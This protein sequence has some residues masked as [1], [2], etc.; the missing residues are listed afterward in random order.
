MGRGS[1][2]R[3]K[4]AVDEA[5]QDIHKLIQFL[6]THPELNQLMGRIWKVIE[7]HDKF[8]TKKRA[9]STSKKAEGTTLHESTTA[10]TGSN[11]PPLS[12]RNDMDATNST[13][14]GETNQG[15][16]DI[17]T[18]LS[19]RWPKVDGTTTSSFKFRFASYLRN[20]V[21]A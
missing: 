1:V 4:V 3:N 5:D 6:T 16:Q 19:K 8:G 15:N 18:E 20:V 17:T 12:Q 9:E 2:R 11:G 21:K 7:L 13:Q 10:T 14:Y